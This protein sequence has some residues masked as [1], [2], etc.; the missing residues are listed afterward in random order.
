MFMGGRMKEMET[1][2]LNKLNLTVQ[3]KSSIKT[4]NE[5]TEKSLKA[6][7]PTQPKPGQKP[8]RPTQAQM[9]KMRSI[10][11]GRHDGLM[12][13][14]TKQ[15]QANYKTLMDKEMKAW[16]AERE[17]RRGSNGAPPV[18]ASKP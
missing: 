14:L 17:K 13:I 11:K 5:K 18:K 9:D 3:Q 8:E 6:L 12:K 16:R 7:R 1:R 2:V 10:S 4:L 15:Q